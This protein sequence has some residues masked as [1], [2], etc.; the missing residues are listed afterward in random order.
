M[1]NS[2]LIGNKKCEKLTWRSLVC[3]PRY[4]YWVYVWI[5][6]IPGNIPPSVHHSSLCNLIIIIIEE[7]VFIFSRLRSF[8][9]R[10]QISLRQGACRSLNFDI[11]VL[12]KAVGLKFKVS[13]LFVPK[14][15]AF[16][17]SVVAA[18]SLRIERTTQRFHG[19]CHDF[20]RFFKIF[21]HCFDFLTQIRKH[22]HAVHLIFAEKETETHSA[23]GY[24]FGYWPAGKA[25]S[26]GA[27]QSKVANYSLRVLTKAIA[28]CIRKWNKYL[29][30]LS[31]LRNWK[32]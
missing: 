30:R 4:R 7:L 6:E 19:A 8:K 9:N 28:G 20:T 1:P 3:I 16:R 23:V 31:R 25:E 2:D 27:Q 10:N 15:G 26:K 32:L 22:Q 21:N 13:C 12:T 18:I 11:W 17:W 5:D 29:L 14:V 24:W